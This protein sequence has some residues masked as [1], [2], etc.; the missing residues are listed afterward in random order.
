MMR[1]VLSLLLQLGSHRAAA[2]YPADVAKGR[3]I[4]NRA[5]TICHGLEGTVGDR[6]P[7]LA[8]NRRYL[9]TTP[10]DLFDAI[11]NGVRGTLMPPAALSDPEVR[12][13]VAYVRSLRATASDTPIKGDVARGGEIF[14][15]KG[16]CGRCHMIEGRGGVLG[17]DLSN[18]GAERRLSALREALT[19]PRRRIPRGYQ[20]ARLVLRDG[21][22][23]EGLVKNE[24]NFSLQVLGLDLRLYLLERTELRELV[25]E[26]ASLMPAD[27]GRRLAAD[28]LRDVLAF[29]S[30]QVRSSQNR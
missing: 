21:R 17:P 22:T 12:K 16:E 23:I 8:G 4:Y 29:L 15:G 24:N 30:R 27:Y 28:E 7:A 1:L 25:R 11:K 3:E 13:V 6:G 18:I 5:C 14:W 9:R 10:E 19:D 20:P 2:L 26:S